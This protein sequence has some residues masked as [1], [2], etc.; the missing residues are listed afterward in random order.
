MYS[1]NAPV[2]SAVAALASDVA[3]DLPAA[4]ERPRGSHTL[5]VKRLGTGDHERYA[6]LEARAREAL[7]GA[8]AVAARVADVAVF[9]DAPIGS[10]PVVYLAVE[11]PGL[12]GIHERL[13]EAFDP[14]DGI[15]GDDYTPHVTIAR[16]GSLEAAR[17]V[18]DA[19]SLEPIEWTIDELVFWDAEREQSI[20]RIALPA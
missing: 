4:R 8:P 1:L 6:R 19:A 17:A 20:S 3:A 14:I 9:E 10:A 12:I 11:S 16:G 5:G 2:P 15:E 13:C 7:A 18:A